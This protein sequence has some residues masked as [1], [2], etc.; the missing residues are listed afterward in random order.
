[1]V[2]QNCLQ[3]IYDC[4]FPID[5][6]LLPINEFCIILGIDW[7][8]LYDIVVNCRLKWIELKC[9]TG[10]MIIVESNK[11]DSTTSVILIILVHSI[12]L[13]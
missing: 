4:D 7:L 13:L 1:M 10:V 6:M 11:S 8:K 9:Q 12:I 5:M 2:Y 3:K